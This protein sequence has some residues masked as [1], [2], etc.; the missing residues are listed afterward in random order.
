[1]GDGGSYLLGFSLASLS[2]IYSSVS[3]SQNLE[4]IINLPAI[5]FLLFIPLVDMVRVIF[6]RIF[7]GYSPFYPDKIHF[8]HVLREKGFNYKKIIF[9]FYFFSI[10]SC[11]I[12]SFIVNQI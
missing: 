6:T 5:V 9:I 4:G 11:F 8:H 10:I 12:S 1:M 7:N 3:S 2:I